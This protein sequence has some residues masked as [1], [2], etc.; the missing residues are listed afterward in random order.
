M[1]RIE[2]NREENK[3]IKAGYESIW[4]KNRTD[5]R[6]IMFNENDALWVRVDRWRWRIRRFPTKDHFFKKC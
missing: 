4:I 5:H 1:R 6:R 2:D 3:K